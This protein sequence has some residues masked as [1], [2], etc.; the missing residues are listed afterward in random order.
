GLISGPAAPGAVRVDAPDVRFR[1]VEGMVAMIER[2]AWERPLV[3][4]I[5]DLHWADPSTLLT[6]HRLTQRLAHVP[7]ALIGTCRPQPRPAELVALL[8][9]LPTDGLH[10]RLGPLDADAARGLA[11]AL[12]DAEPGPR[13]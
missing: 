10:L 9:A 3:L 4:A 6:L 8:G 11:A 7:L 5:D 12:L 1:V 2:L 13:L